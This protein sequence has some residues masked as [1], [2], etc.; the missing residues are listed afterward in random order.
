M[1]DRTTKDEISTAELPTLSG[2]SA[3]SAPEHEPCAVMVVLEGWE[4]GR[5][6]EIGRDDLLV[7][8]SVSANLSIPSPT[9]SRRH[10][11]L[12]CEPGDPPSHRITDLGSANGVWVNGRAVR[13]ARLADRD[14]VQLGEVVLKYVLNDPG[15]RELYRE[16]HRRLHFDP[17]T[18]LLMLDAFMDRLR[19]EISRG[20]GPFSLVMTDL[21]GLK[22]VNDRWGHPVGRSV[23]REMG[24]MIRSVLR[25][26][27]RAGLAGGDEAILLLPAT[28]AEDALEICERLRRTVEARSLEAGEETFSLTITQGVAEWPAD[29]ESAE[30]LVA[31]ADS[32]LAAAKEAGRNRTH[33]AGPSP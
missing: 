14:T 20:A 10:A 2:S 28:R 33:R 23:V 17:L 15:E 32:A 19:V 7:G 6:I 9:I 16:L 31:A 21:D 13:D 26:G 4:P 22:S 25:P 27:D 8:R 12:V 1:D 3:Q 29:G 5:V 24:S 30:D 18:G 11:R